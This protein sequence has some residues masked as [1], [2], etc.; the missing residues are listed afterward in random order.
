MAQLFPSEMMPHKRLPAVTVDWGL[1]LQG[2][3][4]AASNSLVL[5]SLRDTAERTGLTSGGR[6]SPGAASAQGRG[7]GHPRLSPPRCPREWAAPGPHSP[8]LPPV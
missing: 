8:A 5:T 4:A 1:N 6:R 3:P 7:A 2:L